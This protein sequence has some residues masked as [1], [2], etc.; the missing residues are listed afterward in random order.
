M[1]GKSNLSQ[2]SESVTN[3]TKMKSPSLVHC[4]WEQ[5]KAATNFFTSKLMMNMLADKPNIMTAGIEFHQSR[6][7]TRQ[8][9]LIR[10]FAAPEVEIPLSRLLCLMLK[11]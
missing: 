6:Q 9:F 4:G 7:F 1:T 2:K 5:L 8:N 11:L 10:S 3:V